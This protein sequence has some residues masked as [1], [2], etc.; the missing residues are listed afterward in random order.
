MTPGARKT[1]PAG[2]KAKSV[3]GAGQAS[4]PRPSRASKYAGRAVHRASAVLVS[5][6]RV[7]ELEAAAVHALAG[8]VGPAFER[9]VEILFATEGKVVVTGLGKSGIIAR[10]IAATLAST[11]TPAFFVHAGEGLH[12]DLGMLFRGD[13]VLALSN[14]GE[15]SEVIRLLPLFKRLDLPVIALT[16]VLGSR[17]AR[18]ADVA[19]D[20]SVARE[21]CPLE[22]APMASTTAALA[23]GD[24]LA[25]VLMERRGFQERDF[26]YLHPAGGLGRKLLRVSDLM[27]RDR[28][29]PL[30]PGTATLREAIREMTTKRLGTTGIVDR[31]GQLAGILTD[32]D[33]RRALEQREVDLSMP[34]SDRMT[35]RPK[36]IRESA[37]G[38]EALAM[39]EKYQITVLFIVDARKRPCG[40]LHLHDLLQ[41]SVV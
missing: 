27:H 38:A 2:G 33:L 28:T 9:A 5:A 35:R 19:L 1:A 4:T 12:G 37:L 30:V 17:L 32:G 39:M 18:T 10:K 13:S 21:A 11:G 25:V 26:A 16:G 24:A 31:K 41:A 20:V 15:T 8:R 40:V 22:L 36:T 14:S 34:V 29:V 7:L 23:M 3:P 6:R